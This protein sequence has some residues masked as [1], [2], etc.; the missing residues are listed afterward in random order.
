MRNFFKELLGEVRTF[1]KKIWGTTISYPALPRFLFSCSRLCR[2]SAIKK[3]KWCGDPPIFVYPS[4]SS[5]ILLVASRE[6]QAKTL[7]DKHSFTLAKVFRY[8]NSNLIFSLWYLHNGLHYSNPFKS[9][10]IPLS[11]SA[12]FSRNPSI[13]PYFFSLPFFK[14]FFVT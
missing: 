4:Q 14:I 12:I 7:S 5:L 9:L 2:K 6:S 11:S 3:S 1:E 10:Y 13:P 8:I